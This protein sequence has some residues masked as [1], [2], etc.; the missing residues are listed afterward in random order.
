M[1]EDAEDAIREDISS[2][3]DDDEV[4]DGQ[5]CVV[6]LRKRRRAAFIPC[7]HLVCCCK[8]ALRMECEVEPLCPMCRQDIRYMIRIYDS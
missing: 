6:C 7:G 3:D 4:G 2:D 8:C 5:L 1:F